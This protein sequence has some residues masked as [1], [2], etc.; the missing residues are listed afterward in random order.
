MVSVEGII[1]Y[2]VLIDAVGANIAAW[3]C[4]KW[5][6]KNYK[7]FWKH[8][9]VTKAWAAIYLVLVFW[10]GYGLNRLGLI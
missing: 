10:V 6:K 4:A 3:C 7:G 9:P 2:L 8:L 1:W 5:V